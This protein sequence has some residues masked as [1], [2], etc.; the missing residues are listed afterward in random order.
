MELMQEKIT[1]SL[2]NK[3]LVFL[4]YLVIINVVH[5]LF[6]MCYNVL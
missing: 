3:V 4:G 5:L 6:I 1:I 2:I